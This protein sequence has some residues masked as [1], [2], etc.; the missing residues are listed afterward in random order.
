MAPQPIPTT[1]A[2]LL[3]TATIATS[4]V[5]RHRQAM[6]EVAARAALT[7]PQPAKPAEVAK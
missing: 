6:A 3:A 4:N 7:V 1:I 2:E 5:T